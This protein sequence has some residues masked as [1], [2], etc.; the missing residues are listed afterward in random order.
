MS[1]RKG[2][3]TTCGSSPE[4]PGTCAACIRANF[5]SDHSPKRR[6][7]SFGHALLNTMEG[8]ACEAS[9]CQLRLPENTQPFR[10]G[11]LPLQTWN[12]AP[13]TYGKQVFPRPSTHLVLV[14]KRVSR[15][16][17]GRVQVQRVHFPFQRLHDTVRAHGLVGAKIPGV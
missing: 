7:S 5:N 4:N 9:R 16:T 3:A 17:V 12:P 8:K 10:V 6:F 2:T 15:S 1:G 14:R 13:P 11:N